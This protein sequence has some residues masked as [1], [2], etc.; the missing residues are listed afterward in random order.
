MASVLYKQLAKVTH[1]DYLPDY[2]AKC[3][4]LYAGGRRLLCDKKVL[5]DVFPQHGAETVEV[6]HERCHRA[7]YLNYAGSVID[8][9][10]AGLFEESPSAEGTPEP[11]K[12]YADWFTD[13]SRPGGKVLPF[14]DLLKEQVLTALCLRRAWT[15]V[16]LPAPAQ[17]AADGQPANLA[18]QE[19]SGA[20][21][22][23]AVPIDPECVRDWECDDDGELMWALL[24]FKR[25]K[26]A[27]LEG[28]RKTI[29]EEYVY[30]TPEA[31][32]RYVIEYKEDKPPNDNDPV[33]LVAEGPHSF[34]RVPLS[35]L[36]LT[37]GMWAMGKLESIAAA[38]MNAVNALSW[39]TLKSLFPTPTAYIAAEDMGNE[40]TSDSRRAVTQ[41]RGPSNIV[42]LGE[43]DRFEY[44]G[45][46]ADPFDH[47]MSQADRL[48]DEMYRVV[49]SMAASVDNSGAALQRSGK[50]KEMDMHHTSTILKWLGQA[51]SRHAVEVLHLVG[52]GRAD[53][54]TEWQIHGM[55]EFD[56]PNAEQML[57][58]AQS[59]DT[60]SIPSATFQRLYK[61]TIAKEC[62]GDDATGEDLDTIKKELEGN[63]SNE[64]F[65][66]PEVAPGMPGEPAED[67]EKDKKAERPEPKEP[68]VKKPRKAKKA[69]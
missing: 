62:L 27:G 10:V 18:E 57:A 45:P 66:A 51:V 43:K 40:I 28:D 20:L 69:E 1:P 26:R 24:A 53:P 56:A 21:D 64:M 8:L 15:L 6:Y 42:T 36:E 48:R 5:R 4:A 50:S 63:I 7:Y 34:G 41:A 32:Q 46:S 19:Q 23:Y 14:N 60:I 61:F 17:G 58:E 59:V 33:P 12:W 22:C 65:Q 52:A 30:Y 39:A 2:W 44:V 35:V 68:A 37:D 16:E 29:E 25:Q 54:E 49:H 38:H 9:I 11:D 47:A 3:R 55:E 67:E 13:V 31:F